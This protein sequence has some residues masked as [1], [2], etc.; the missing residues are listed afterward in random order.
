MLVCNALSAV[1]LLEASDCT[2]EVIAV[3][4]ARAVGIWL[5]VG[6]VNSVTKA[7]PLSF[8]TPPV[9]HKVILLFT[10]LVSFGMALLAVVEA[11]F[12]VVLSPG[13]T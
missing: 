2:A 9:D 8:I 13:L 10:A 4:T 5:S 7:F 12:Q 6:L 3:F 11:V 1:L